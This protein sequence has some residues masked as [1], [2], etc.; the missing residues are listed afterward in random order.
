[1]QDS[2]GSL[3]NRSKMVLALTLKKNVLLGSTPGKE[4]HPNVLP[5]IKRKQKTQASSLA[6]IG[7]VRNKPDAGDEIW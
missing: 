2:Q 3:F 4:S 6:E 1:M 7:T 5:R